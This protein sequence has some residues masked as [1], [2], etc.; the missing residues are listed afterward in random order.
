MSHRKIT[1]A[2]QGN[3]SVDV[4]LLPVFCFCLFRGRRRSEKLLERVVVVEA[5]AAAVAV[6][7]DSFSVVLLDAVD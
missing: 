5:T 6:T 2:H 7:I 3:S 1:T 4:G